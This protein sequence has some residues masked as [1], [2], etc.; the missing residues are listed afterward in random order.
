MHRTAAR[1]VMRCLES[2]T[3]QH[4]STVNVKQD[5]S[6]RMFDAVSCIRAYLNPEYV[7][8]VLVNLFV[9]KSTNPYTFWI[10]L[11]AEITHLQLAKRQFRNI[12]DLAANCNRQRVKSDRADRLNSNKKKQLMPE[13]KQAKQQ[14]SETMKQC[15]RVSYTQ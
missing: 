1:A 12:W 7:E 5:G 8:H 2:K 10:E 11:I 4:C 14:N 13:P 6:F 3:V 9:D 15:S